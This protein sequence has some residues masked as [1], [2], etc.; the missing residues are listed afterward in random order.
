MHTWFLQL[1]TVST[2]LQ[3]NTKALERFNSRH[4]PFI[5]F[6]LLPGYFI[7]TLLLPSPP[8]LIIIFKERCFLSYSQM[9]LVC[10]LSSALAPYFFLHGHYA[11]TGNANSLHL[12]C[13]EVP[14]TVDI[15]IEYKTLDWQI[16][17]SGVWRDYFI[18]LGFY[19]VY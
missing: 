15:C 6:I 1:V 14:F 17:F 2:L 12:F 19:S 13:L 11:F 10:L 8:I 4:P 3:S 7:S 9:S 16:V 18:V 5:W